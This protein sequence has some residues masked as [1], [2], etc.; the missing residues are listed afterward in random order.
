MG[1]TT[2]SPENAPPGS[3]TRCLV[4][5]KIER[6]C[7]YS[8]KRNYIEQ[9]IWGFYAWQSIEDGDLSLE[10]QIKSLKEDN[11]HGRCVWHCDNDVV[12]HQNVIVEFADGSV[13]THV[14]TGGTSKPSR[15]MHLIGTKGEI[16]GV[17]A[18]GCLQVRLSNGTRIGISSGE[19]SVRLDRTASPC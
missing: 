16:E 4:D 2:T 10:A 9:G 13:A 11:P 17:D 12:D 18:D 8:A 7:E 5:C 14:M 6:E 3:G 15:T 19:V 1:A